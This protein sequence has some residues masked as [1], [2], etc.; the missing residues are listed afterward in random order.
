MKNKLSG[1]IAFAKAYR[2]PLIFILINLLASLIYHFPFLREDNWFWRASQ[3]YITSFWFKQEGINLINYQTPLFGPPWQVPYEFPLYQALCVIVS[4]VFSIHILT[5]SHITS[6]LIFYTSAILLML[7]CFQYFEDLFTATV[8]FSVYLWIP[9]N[10]LY[11]N[12]ILIDFMALMFALGFI[13]LMTCWFDNPHHWLMALFAIIS[14]SLGSMV[15]V[16]TM[17]IIVIPF[18]FRFF[19]GLKNQGFNF[20]SF[21]KP[22][23]IINFVKEHRLFTLFT[24]LM[25]LIPLIATVLWTNFTDG[26]K[27]ANPSIVGLSSAGLKDWNF[28]TWEQKLDLNNWL[29]WL[30]N[31]RLYYLSGFV[32]LFALLPCLLIFKMTAKSRELI[33][34][35]ALGSFLSIFIFFNLYLHEY[36][37]ISISACMSILIGYGLSRVIQ[38][39]QKRSNVWLSFSLMLL[40][41]FFIIYPQIQLYD[42]FR[43]SVNDYHKYMEE[44][45]YSI[46]RSAKE[47]TPPGEY[48]IIVQENWEPYIAVATE[49]KVFLFT[50]MSRGFFNCN[51]LLP[52]PYTTLIGPSDNADTQKALACYDHYQEVSP[53]VYRLY[54]K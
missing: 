28:G 43:Q 6:L 34:A 10:F 42:S 24:V 21:Y 44:D 52:Y 35:S 19:H 12:E 40:L 15:K 14:L 1:M 7:I 32:M 45:F 51:M 39:V 50:H 25:V 33:I 11:S 31:I 5:A 9:Y 47:V 38:F 30:S 13:Y 17:P 18:I 29:K 54:K 46:G 53:E 8:I 37:Y 4:N 48:I 2:Y 20:T 22:T 23:E 16:T 3:T 36:Y 26:I 27:F 49:R 41:G